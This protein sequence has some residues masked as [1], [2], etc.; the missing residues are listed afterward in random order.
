M[1]EMDNLNKNEVKK[2]YAG[3]NKLML[4]FRLIAAGYVLYLSWTLVES[5]IKG[6]GMPLAALICC[7]TVFV[8]I[9]AIII[10]TSVKALIKGEYAGGK[11][12]IGTDETI[13]EIAEVKTEDKGIARNA[14]LL[15]ERLQKY[16]E[17][18]ENEE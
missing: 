8:I 14:A 10:Y 15:S 4:I 6:E 9:S 12:D 3:T 17:E 16:N 18:Q 5:Y 11:A 13:E 2:S 7:V 1:S